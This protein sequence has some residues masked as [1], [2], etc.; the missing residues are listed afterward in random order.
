MI[1]LAHYRDRF[2]ARHCELCKRYF[3]A[4]RSD[5]RTCSNACRMALSRRKRKPVTCHQ[6]IK[7]DEEA[8][9]NP[10]PQDA[11]LD[12]RIEAIGK[13]EAADFIKR[14]EY[15]GTTGHAF[16]RYGARNVKG[17]LAAVA[18]FGTP[19]KLLAGVVVLER[20]ACASWAHPHCASWFIPRAVAMAARDHG[21]R[22]FHVYADPACGEIGTVYQAC[23]WFYTGQTP[24]RLIDGAPRA[25]DYFRSPDG[26]RVISDRS[27]YREGHTIEDVGPGKWRRVPRIAKHRYVWFE[28]SKSERRAFLRGLQV[29]PYPKRF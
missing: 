10:R 23:N 27:F 2:P 8:R 29:L 22:V 14:Y 5:A 4:A 25:R 6:R 19:T 7:R 26:R 1:K 13:R 17:E 21:W 9:A 18:L 3:V 11:T 20:G 24:G 16:A 15:L 12:Y 28:G